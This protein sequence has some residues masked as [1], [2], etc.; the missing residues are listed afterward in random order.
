M[1]RLESPIGA[2]LPQLPASRIAPAVEAGDN[3]NPI[4]LQ[5]EE[6]AVGESPHSSA[7][8]VPVHDRE[9]QW[10]FGHCFNRALDP[11]RETLSKLR[12]NVVIPCPR[13][14]QIFIRSW[15]PDD[16]EFH[17]LLN[18]SVLTCSHGMVSD[19]FWSCRAIRWSSSA[20]CAS[21]SDA[22]SASRLSQTVSSNS[23][24][25]AGER[26]LIW[27]LKSLIC[28]YPSAVSL[29]HASTPLQRLRVCGCRVKHG[30]R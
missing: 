1:R 11:Q 21:V 20:R 13:F 5:F 30:V 27:F 18:R 23:A 4:I 7:P 24:F 17:G 12:A 29:A 10:M 16:R 22:A 15:Y 9:L 3:Y 26:L 6:Y 19:G 25:S 14:Q 2:D 8:E 28:L